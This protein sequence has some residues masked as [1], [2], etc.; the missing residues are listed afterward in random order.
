[1]RKERGK[2]LNSGVIELAYAAAREAKSALG[3]GSGSR[4]CKT[5]NKKTG[6]GVGGLRYRLFEEVKEEGEDDESVRT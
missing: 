3:A 2:A 1:M 6:R 4:R 5:Q